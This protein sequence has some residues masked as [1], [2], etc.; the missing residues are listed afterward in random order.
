MKTNKEF[1]TETVKVV[2][3]LIGL[4]RPSSKTELNMAMDM[5]A[6][7]VETSVEQHMEEHLNAAHDAARAAT[8]GK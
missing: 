1:A 4:M 3:A 6:M 8:E 2:M 7:L 5:A